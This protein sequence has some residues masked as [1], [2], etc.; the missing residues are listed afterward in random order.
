MTKLINWIKTLLLEEYEL[1][2][3]YKSGTEFDPKTTKRVYRLKSISKKTQTHFKGVKMNGHSL[4]S[5]QQNH[6]TTR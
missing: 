3:W 6:L 2:V 4:K 5:K 1:T